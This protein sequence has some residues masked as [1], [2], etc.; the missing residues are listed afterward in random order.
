MEKILDIDIQPQK[1]HEC[2]PCALH[3]ILRYY[4]TQT[5]RDELIVDCSKESIQMRDWDYRIGITALKHGYGSEITTLATS[6]YDPSWVDLSMEDLSK[7]LQA[8]IEVYQSIINKKVKA[9]EEYSYEHDVEFELVEATTALQFIQQG[10]VVRLMPITKELLVDYLSKDIA[11]IAGVNATLLHKKVR[12]EGMD[13]DEHRG[14]VWSHM[15]I[16]SGYNKTDFHISDPGPW[17]D[18][19]QKYWREKDWVIESIT[20]RDQNIIAILPKEKTPNS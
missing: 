3:D 1:D 20:R 9:P 13:N 10:G 8:Q 6:I 4:G 18:S 17:Y 16:I 15:L 5:D 14:S 11:I 12:K 7:K 19:S 2:G